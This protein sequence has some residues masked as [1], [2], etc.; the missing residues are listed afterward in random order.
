MSI[1]QED[2]DAFEV[3]VRE[4]STLDDTFVVDLAGFE[5]P[6]DVLLELARTQ[7][8]DLRQVSILALVEQYLVFVAE[9]QKLRL[10]LAADYL[11]MA[12]WL[13]YLKSRLLLPD[14]KNDEEPPAEELAARLSLQLQRLDAMR[15]MSVR[16]MAQD[17]M[18]VDVFPRGA[19]EGI[20]LVRQPRYYGTLFDLLKAYAQHAARTDDRPLEVARRP[21]YAMEAALERLNSLLGMALEWTL[22]QGFLPDDTTADE[23]VTESK[24]AATFAAALEIAREGRLEIHQDRHFGPLYLRKSAK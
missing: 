10:E 13:A 19:P 15:K 14:D 11:V 20:K 24:V 8:V 22:L 2:I 6:I 9:A 4:G 1:S 23:M 12:A 3:P 7:K 21:I 17:R 18:G 16:L 5:G